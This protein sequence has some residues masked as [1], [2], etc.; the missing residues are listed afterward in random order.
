MSIRGDRRSFQDVL[1]GNAAA[2]TWIKLPA[3]ESVELMALGGFDFV[4]ID[5]EHA[6]LDLQTAYLQIG[7]AQAAGMPALVRIPEVTAGF[8]QRVLDAGADGLL[9]PHVDTPA[10]ARA[11]VAA[12][13]FPPVGHRGAGFTSRAG[14]WGLVDG[15][16]Y[17]RHGNETVAVIPQLESRT[18][19]DNTSEIA[20]VPGVTALFLGPADLALSLGVGQQSEQVVALTRT[21]VA[22]A[23]ENHLPIGTAVGL[24]PAAV[25]AGR[26]L[27]FDYLMV[28][29]DAG[30]LGDAARRAVQTFRSPTD[31]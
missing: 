20:A 27:G 10:D 19:V 30:L 9:I 18:A 15:A 16:D 1:A 21:A 17:L 7:A 14:R 22:R 4:V 12:A 8:V 13:R 2:G 5:L 26:D 24:S 11:A 28:G 29:N 31:S 23:H 3:V 6:P 25:R